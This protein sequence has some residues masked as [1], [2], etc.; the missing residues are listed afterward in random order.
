MNNKVK[1][2]LT[3]A[4]VAAMIGLGGAGMILPYSGFA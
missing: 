3:T 2:P 4:I 1:K